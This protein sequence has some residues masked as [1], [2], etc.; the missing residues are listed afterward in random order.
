MGNS[1]DN[2]RL[3]DAAEREPGQ[4][5]GSRLSPENIA[6]INLERRV[7]YL[8]SEQKR[9]TNALISAGEFIFKNPASKMMLAAFPKEMQNRLKE[10]FESKQSG[11][12]NGT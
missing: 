11:K 1:P 12:L 10:F 8:E 4:V 3:L 5:P 9:F 6:L 2:H 7:A